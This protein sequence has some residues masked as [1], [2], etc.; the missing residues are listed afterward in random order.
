MSTED[1]RRWFHGSDEESFAAAARKAVEDA[2]S[3][4]PQPWPEEY[5]VKL[6]VG[7]KGVLSD[8]R[9]LVSPTNP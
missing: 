5:D 2:E 1:E 3:K 8:Y 9:V 6:R 7:A 4:L